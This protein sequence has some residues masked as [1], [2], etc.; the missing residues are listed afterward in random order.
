M[1][2]R[3]PKYQNIPTPCLFERAS[4]SAAQFSSVWSGTVWNGF[5]GLWCLAFISRQ[6]ILILSRKIKH[7]LKENLKKSPHLLPTRRK[8]HYRD[9]IT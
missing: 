1:N 3:V 2:R 9:E 7:N 6:R 8:I 4:D 5:S